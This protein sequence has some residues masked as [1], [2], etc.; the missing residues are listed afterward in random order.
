MKACADIVTIAAQHAL[1]IK[2]KALSL[3]Q[4]IALQRDHLKRLID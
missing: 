2:H 1:L 4:K 3:Y